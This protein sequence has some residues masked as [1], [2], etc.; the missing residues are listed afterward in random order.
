M[1]TWKR[2]ATSMEMDAS[3]SMWEIL[4]PTVK[5]NTEG[6]KF[7]TTRFHRVWDERVRAISGGLTIMT[8]SKGQWLSPHGTLFVERMI[9]VRI[10]STREEVLKIVEMTAEYYSQEAV[11]CYKVSDDVIFHTNK[12]VKNAN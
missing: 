12:G 4:V 3:K 1:G 5:P 11:L 6:K 9:P 10:V 8:P 2:K 7:F